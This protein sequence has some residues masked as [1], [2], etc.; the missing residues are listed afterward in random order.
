[1]LIQY[2]RHSVVPNKSKG[3]PYGVVIAQKDE[4]GKV[5]YG[6]SKCHVN[7]VFSKEKALMIAKNRSKNGWNAK[8]P[9][10]VNHYMNSM[11]LRAERY[12]K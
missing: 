7:D 2:L 4:T 9:E 5:S 3:I 10:D 8:I 6:W 12:Y 1:M 11:V